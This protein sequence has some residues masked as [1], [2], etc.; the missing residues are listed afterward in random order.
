[1][2]SGNMLEQAGLLLTA[3]VL[4]LLVVFLVAFMCSGCFFGSIIKF[5][6]GL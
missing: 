3:V 6:L 4:F 1:M 2:L 5:V